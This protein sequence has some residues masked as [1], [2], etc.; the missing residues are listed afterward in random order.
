DIGS[1]IDDP[2]FRDVVAEIVEAIEGGST[3]SEALQ[4]FPGIFGNVYT[5]MVKVGEES[6]RLVAV[7]HDLTGMLRWQDEMIAYAKRVMVYPA[8]VLAVVGGVVVFLMMYLV[9]QLTSFLNTMG[10]ELPAHT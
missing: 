1:T 5:S 8:I 4:L 9:P 2:S 3:F 10:T 6:G 7:L